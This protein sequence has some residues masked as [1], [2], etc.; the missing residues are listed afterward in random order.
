MRR[1][2]Q[3]PQRQPQESPDSIPTKKTNIHEKREG[4][5]RVFISFTYKDKEYANK[6]YGLLRKIP[7]IEIFSLEM[8][9][10]GEDWESRLRSEIWKSDIF[11]VLLSE[12]SIN[13]K[14]VLHEVGAAW[15]L[16]KRILPIVTNPD[17][18]S[19]IPIDWQ[20]YQVIRLVDLDKP[21]YLWQLLEIKD[22]IEINS[23]R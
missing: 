23:P 19:K 16:G 8:I 22:H 7:N 9:T 6:M 12:N 18:I 14:S 3:G 13:S 15:A 1:K 11:I 4:I 20:K 2:A 17:I 10:A 21:E 5:L